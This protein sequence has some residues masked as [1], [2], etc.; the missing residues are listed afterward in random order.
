MDDNLKPTNADVAVIGMACRFPDARDY[1]AYW[2]NLKNSVSSISEIPENRWDTRQYYSQDP[3][4]PNTSVSKWAGLLEDIASFDNEFFHISPR[5]AENMDPQ[6]RLLLEEAWHCIEDAGVTPER[7][8]EHVTSVYVGVMAVDYQQ[9]M[10]EC[11]EPTDSHACLGNYEGILA[12]R[13]SFQLGLTGE[14]QSIDTACSSSL[15]ALHDAKRSVNTGE[16]EYAFAAG[17]N[18][19][20]H[21]WK[22]ISFS[23][24]RMLSPDGQ[25]KT[26]DKDANGYVPGEGVGILLLTSIENA[27]KNGHRIHGILKGSAVNHTGKNL[28]MTAPRMEAQRDVIRAA[29]KAA[30]VSPH[31]ISYIEA[32]GTGTSL[33]DPIEVEGLI[34]AFQAEKTQYCA[35]GSVKTNIGHLE[36][37]AGVAGV[38]KVL[39]MLKHRELVPTLNVHTVNPIIDFEHSPF[40]LSMKTQPW[41]ALENERRMAGVSSFGFGGTNAHVIL[42]E[43][44]EESSLPSVMPNQSFYPFVLSAKTSE[45]LEQLIE[46]WKNYAASDVFSHLKMED[47]SHT[48]LQ[49]RESFSWRFSCLL[50]RK[51]E[52]LPKLMLGVV[53][54]VGLE[55]KPLGAFILSP[56]E[57]LSFAQWEMLC[58]D[59]PAFSRISEPFLQELA[60]LNYHDCIKLLESG[61]IQKK[62]E[63]GFQLLVLYV[64]GRWL[65]E[66]GVNPEVIVGAG[67]GALA[68]AVLSGIMDLSTAI[69]IAFKKEKVF[70]LSYRVPERA[71]AAP[72]LKARIEPFSI[73]ADY[74]LRMRQSLEFDAQA[75][76]LLLNKS[77]V[78]IENQF[79]FKQYIHEYEPALSALGISLTTIIVE[80]E[81][82]PN[83]KYG[84]IILLMVLAICY[85]K[86]SEKWNLSEKISVKNV[87]LSELID[88]ILDEALPIEMAFQLIDPQ[89]PITYL[90]HISRQLIVFRDR[91][92]KTKPYVLLRQQTKLLVS[93][94]LE[95]WQKELS[96]QP[97]MRQRNLDYFR[98]MN[99]GNLNV[100]LEKE[101]LGFR[102]QDAQKFILS[103]W[104]GGVLH[105]LNQD[106]MPLRGQAL[107]LPAYPFLKR[108]FMISRK[109]LEKEP[110]NPVIT[111]PSLPY[112]QPSWTERSLHSIDIAK[113]SPL[114][115]FEED[116]YRFSIL[117]RSVLSVAPDS[118]II[119]VQKGAFY[120]S[121]STKSFIINPR[122]PEDFDRLLVD[123]F[124]ARI[125]PRS[126]IN[127]W[128]YPL[129]DIFE[130][131][132]SSD[133]YMAEGL[134]ALLLLS[135]ALSRAK[136]KGPLVLLNVHE[137]SVSKSHAL[138][139]M[140]AGLAQ[141]LL[142]ENP[143][144][145]FKTVGLDRVSRISAVLEECVADVASSGVRYI[146]DI[147]FVQST[148]P[149]NFSSDENLILR[150]NG[151]YI[152]TDGMNEFGF[153]LSQYLAEHYQARLIISGREIINDRN[154]EQLEELKVLGSQAIYVMGDISH[155]ENAKHL[156]EI[157][158]SQFQCIN[159]IFHCDTVLGPDKAA[160]KAQVFYARMRPKID[161][162]LNVD[163]AC[164]GETL[165]N[166]LLL[167]SDPHGFGDVGPDYD[168]SVEAPET[169][170]KPC[171][172]ITLSAP[173]EN[174][175]HQKIKELDDY[176]RQ[177][178]Y[179]TVHLSE[180]SYALNVGPVH[181]NYRCAWVLDVDAHELD[182]DFHYRAVVSQQNKEDAPIYKK[183]LQNVVRD[184]QPPFDDEKRYKNSLKI[185]A[186]LYTKGH[187]ID[188]EWLHKNEGDYR[189]YLPTY[190][191]LEESQPEPEPPPEPGSGQNPEQNQQELVGPIAI[192]GMSGRYPEAENLEQFWENLR[193]GKDCITEIPSDRWDHQKTRSKWGGFIQD[194]DKFDP[195]YF[196]I[197]VQEAE[198]MD[199]QERLMLETGLKVIEDAGYSV[200]LLHEKTQGSVGVFVGLMWNDYPLLHAASTENGLL[201]ANGNN[202]SISNRLSYA[203]DFNGPSL[204]IETGC[205][206][207]L[208]AIQLACD[209]IRSGACEYAIAGGVNLSL[210]PSKYIN[211]SALGLLSSDGHCRSF[212][213][214]GD[215]F[216]PAE[217]VGAVLLKPLEK[218]QKD[219]DFIYGIIIGGAVNHGGKTNGFRVPNPEAQ[220]KVTQQALKK[221]HVDPSTI[222]YIEAHGVGTPQGDAIEIKGL[223]KAFSEFTSDT[224]FCAIGSVKSNVGNL[225]SAAG[226]A[227][228]TKVLL[229]FQ[230]QQYV[231]SLHSARINPDIDFAQTPFYVP[232][233]L[234]KWPSKTYPRRAGISSFGITGTNAH[235]I[236]EEA[237]A[238]EL[239]IGLQKPYYLI[240]LSAKNE[241]V[242]KQK[243]MDL[244]KWSE[245]HLD[246]SLADVSFTLNTGRS[247]F[248]YRAAIVVSSLSDLQ[249]VNRYFKGIIS[250]EK[251]NDAAIFR[252]ILSSLL[253]ELKSPNYE[254]E[255]AYRENLE[256]LGNFYVKGYD[257]DWDFVHQD[258]SKRRVPLP[259][260]PFLRN[261]YWIKKSEMIYDQKRPL[262]IK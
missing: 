140:S 4:K 219:N 218:A 3:L 67:A 238:R 157:A 206:S 94:R 74:F 170:N 250:N 154:E 82:P 95:E 187:E 207:S 254:D 232:Q 24:S 116:S 255:L 120:R 76:D 48:L 27:L 15:V 226:V 240:T 235:I 73:S 129:D 55:K 58:K 83:E 28:S 1:A 239:I 115:I 77:R 158:K 87:A 193:S 257:I 211:M 44:P 188:F 132:T 234:Q 160:L 134:G 143:R 247:H 43:Y 243:I 149:V 85:K 167:S 93:V 156:V 130:K 11:H 233:S 7:L 91:L 81:E 39:L 56:C 259:P 36:A 245:Q 46:Q 186:N 65:L 151:V 124:D 26:F 51:E 69:K 185:L 2:E 107:S 228:L 106:V 64:L 32:H 258:E 111:P 180:I 49:G 145:F 72:F 241:P 20:C 25:C 75:L 22:Y 216:V 33:G 242:L 52:V 117:S 122:D 261:R 108:H 197:S 40:Y 70:P 159:G 198:L 103:L 176:L 99:Q 201:H 6:Q 177:V 165:D 60:K 119:R 45:A 79:T 100:M 142:R 252:K 262:V 118:V 251:T 80:H 173:N 92:N 37:A 105:H 209:H 71:F 213:E 54:N 131:S 135:Q 101:L 163:R 23:K 35:L 260:Y 161:A 166:F 220:Y 17:V 191:F 139:E 183:M 59:Y 78:L 152:I 155:Y 223:T 66:N 205:S 8:Q 12:N 249:D 202:S 248:N 164:A 57:S 109:E 34:Q 128:N 30:A 225:E 19:I 244:Q 50:E 178:D 231:P 61:S 195:Q 10:A 190:P 137:E 175:L 104:E 227:A 121:L 199:P 221:S 215:G 144:Y 13:I 62:H 224:Q 214:G 127:C 29:Q 14:S 125:R 179:H 171:Y 194:V 90:S 174:A 182:P 217:G 196:S 148:V 102:A 212:G 222:H 169:S 136:S 89:T 229:Q 141:A 114:L 253:R 153:I 5:E 133:D 150:K 9:R 168:V 42:A 126:F 112:Y 68:A 146:N 184:L 41:V 38:I 181:H 203:Y 123:L 110:G 237:P 53:H 200:E 88:L 63:D 18:I 204:V 113:T 246:S 162:T 16:S 47:I 138:H 84:Q 172:L 236:V 208:V 256:T 86:L 192:I 210:H 147:R 230:H 189:I 97:S 21:P 98:S 96:D 31:D